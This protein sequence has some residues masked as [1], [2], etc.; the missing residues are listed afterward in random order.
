MKNFVVYI[1]FI[2]FATTL[3]AQDNV[4]SL[5]VSGSATPLTVSAD[6]LWNEAN[7][8]YINGEYHQAIEIYN[9]IIE[10]GVSSMRLYYNIGNAYFK[11]NQLA[12]AI[13]YYNRAVKIA[14]GN[15]D[16]KYNLEIAESATK[17]SI[18]AIP[19]FFVITWL[20][21]LQHIMG[22][23]A[24]SII[25]LSSLFLMLSLV[26]F[27]LL[28]QRLA[29][30]KIGFYGSLFMLIIFIASTTFASNERESIINS[31]EA[32]VMSSAISVKS[33]P[34][35]SSTDLFVIHEGTKVEVIT[36]INN[37]CEVTITDGRK[38]W[39]ECRTVE[40]I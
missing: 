23:L 1:I 26:I 37:W 35:S 14:P 36:N 20:V 10:S 39:V 16:I 7:T 8:A 33:S 13:L 9:E 4:D 29:L 31:R 38:G 21:A 19:E 17:D 11:D 3:Y 32:I 40:T 24:W 34:D 28:S 25:S 12:N 5:K 30:R 22:P 2:L 6:I 18:E 15:N 27:Y